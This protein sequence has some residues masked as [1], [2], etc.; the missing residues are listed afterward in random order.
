MNDNQ[1]N[2]RERHDVAT[3]IDH[4][5]STSDDRVMGTVWYHR[6]GPDPCI[7]TGAIRITSWGGDH[8]VID[9]RVNDESTQIPANRIIEIAYNADNNTENNNA[10]M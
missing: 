4:D 8:T 6:D 7:I 9:V 5:Q 2:T 1:S 10:G 3:R